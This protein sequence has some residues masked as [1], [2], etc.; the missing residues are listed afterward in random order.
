[1]FKRINIGVVILDHAADRILFSNKYF[2]SV[3]GENE[4]L[5]ITR[6]VRHLDTR[7]PLSVRCDMPIEGDCIIGYTIYK[8]S[9]SKYLV[10]VGDIS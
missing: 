6:I 10:F 9:A 2:K 8:F 5:I 4:D 7:K 1:M 3:A